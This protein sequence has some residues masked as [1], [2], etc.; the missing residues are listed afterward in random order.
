M[1]FTNDKIDSFLSEPNF[2]RTKH[3]AACSSGKPYFVIW[4]STSLDICPKYKI[5]IYFVQ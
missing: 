4:P 2:A 5:K 1:Q 3:C